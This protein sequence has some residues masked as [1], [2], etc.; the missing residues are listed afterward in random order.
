MRKVLSTIALLLAACGGRD[1]PP[2]A[3][4]A[5]GGTIYPVADAGSGDCADDFHATRI[6]CNGLPSD[7]YRACVLAA[8]DRFE[9]C[10]PPERECAIRC[11][12][13]LGITPEGEACRAAC[14]A[15]DA[16]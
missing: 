10:L 12:D 16:G 1:I 14:L 15:P 5:D 13:E 4:R 6:L 11:T 9:G 7:E 2:P 3:A 8:D